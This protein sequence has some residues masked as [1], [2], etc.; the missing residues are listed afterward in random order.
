MCQGSSVVQIK[1]MQRITTPCPDWIAF[2]CSKILHTMQ[3]IDSTLL[4]ISKTLNTQK[5]CSAT[6]N[7]SL[8]TILIKARW[9]AHKIRQHTHM[10]K[11]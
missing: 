11:R 8:P 10:Q 5:S 3:K 7:L 4:K 2:A 1:D 9:K 6:D